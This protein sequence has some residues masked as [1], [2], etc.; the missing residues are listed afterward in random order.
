MK[1]LVLLLVLGLLVTGCS[2][3]VEESVE[4]EEDNQIQVENETTP[5]N[6]S[7]E[8]EINTEVIIT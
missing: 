3:I 2:T 5:T 8:M 7:I 6:V 4:S 1:L